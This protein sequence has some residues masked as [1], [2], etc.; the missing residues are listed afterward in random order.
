MKLDHTGC[1]THFFSNTDT[2][3]L[4]RVNMAY[5][6]LSGSVPILQ[7]LENLTQVIFRENE[8]DSVSAQSF[9]RT[10]R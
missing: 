5:N 2:T 3:S 6:K 10:R 8:F 1:V 9:S 7:D 4:E